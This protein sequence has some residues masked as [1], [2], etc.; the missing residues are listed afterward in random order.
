MPID[1]ITDL[2]NKEAIGKED[3]LRTLAPASKLEDMI[4]EGSA[5]PLKVL[6]EIV[7]RASVLGD[8][9]TGE[10]RWEEARLAYKLALFFSRDKQAAYENAAVRAEEARTK[11]MFAGLARGDAPV[12]TA[13]APSAPEE[14]PP[15]PAE[16]LPAKPGIMQGSAEAYSYL[17]QA[18][19]GYE[20]PAQPAAGQGQ[21]VKPKYTDKY[22]TDPMHAYLVLAGKD[23]P[24]PETVVRIIELHLA[25]DKYTVDLAMKHAVMQTPEMQARIERILKGQKG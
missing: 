21:E 9:F 12:I 7:A 4:K 24:S 10:G 16:D 25:T 18:G 8:R 19:P 2:L 23:P 1:E 3:L 17:V 15:A 14:P 20:A 13:P 6:K 5:V 11:R 22:L